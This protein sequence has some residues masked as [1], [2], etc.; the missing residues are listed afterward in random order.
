MKDLH[1]V[2]SA[3]HISDYKLEITFNDGLQA[4][5]DFSPWIEKYEIFKPLSDLEYFKNFSLDGWT[6]VWENGADVAPERLYEI[7]AGS[8]SLKAA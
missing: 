6:V 7:A 2:T 8:E 4:E 5:I 3:R 1:L